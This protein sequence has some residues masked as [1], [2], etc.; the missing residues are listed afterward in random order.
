MG[1]IESFSADRTDP[2]KMGFPGYSRLAE[3]GCAP[4]SPGKI[5]KRQDL[6][7]ANTYLQNQ[8]PRGQTGSTWWLHPNGD[9]DFTLLALTVILCQFGDEP[10]VLYPTTREHLLSTLL[11]EDGGEVRE[12]VPRSLGLVRDTENHLLMTEGARY[13]KNRWLALHGNTAP[14]YDNEKNGVETWLLHRTA[15]W[16]VE[17]SDPYSVQIGHGPESS[18]EIYS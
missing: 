9:Y 6:E 11:V 15:R 1:K 17:K 12:T 3:R 8:V 18:P 13:L 16:V 7:A 5:T 4:R 10:A 14:R 2:A